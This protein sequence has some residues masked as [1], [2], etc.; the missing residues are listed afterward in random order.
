MIDQSIF[1]N[2]DIRGVAGSELTEDAAYRIAHAFA[3]YASPKTVLVGMDARRSSQGLR[4]AVV[5]GLTERGVDVVD[6]GLVSTD[7]TYFSAWKYGIDGSIMVTA[8]HMPAQ[9]NGLKFLR[10]LD[11]ALTPIGRGLGMEELQEIANREDVVQ[12]G[13]NVGTVSEKDIWDDFVTFTHSFVDVNAIKPMHVVMDAGNGMGGLVADKVFAGLPIEITRLYFEP[14]GTFPNHPANPIEEKNRQD[15]IA[16]IKKSGADL[17]VAWDADCD[18]VYLFDEQGTF[19]NAS[20]VLVLM[21]LQQLAK[22]PGATI[23]HDVRAS[24]VVKD[25]IEAAGGRVVEEKVGHT[26]IKPT[27]REHDAII[28]GEVSGHY[29]FAANKYMESGFAPALMIMEM[30]STSQKNLSELIADLGHYYI[31]DEI[32]FRVEDA[33]AVL[34]AVEEAFNDAEIQKK[35]GVS[36]IYEDWHANVRKSANDPVVRLNIE[37][38]SQELLDK[39]YAA[40]RGVIGG[41]EV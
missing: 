1:R 34:Q 28:G 22:H 39:Q 38:T 11:G 35:D 15:I 26:Y 40:V 33:D 2:Y 9:Y 32:N 19:I 10:M 3:T 20:Y 21:G 8:S 24:W 23:V 7:A 6:I 17:G 13:S 30:M 5:K 4:D 41:E 25:K 16:K 12:Q 36:I 29:Y 31:S 37:A 27:M 18:R 14:D